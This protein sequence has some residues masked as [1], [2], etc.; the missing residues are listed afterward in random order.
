MTYTK[1]R[2]MELK[3]ST[4]VICAILI[5]ATFL[6]AIGPAALSASAATGATS[7]T[8]KVSGVW[9]LTKFHSVVF[10]T[11]DG[12]QYGAGYGTG[13]ITGGIRGSSQGE[14]LTAFNLKTGVILFTGQIH[15]ECTIDGKTGS[16]WISM[17]NGVDHNANKPNGKTTAE[18][19]IV[20]ASGQLKGTTGRGPMVTTTS[21][22]DMNFTML[23]HL[24]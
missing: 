3:Q 21:S 12:I 2:G 10:Y 6:L 8:I 15:C 13:P 22:D 11:K 14:Y 24:G 9:T 1:V 19:V 5:A 16:L 4:K 7:A 17:I 18:F 23:I 20:G